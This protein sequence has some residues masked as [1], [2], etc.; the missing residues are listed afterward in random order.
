M[1][2]KNPQLPIRGDARIA[3]KRSSSEW[4]RV[5]S[6]LSLGDLFLE[7]RICSVD[8]L[9]YV[10]LCSSMFEKSMTPAE[11]CW[12]LKWKK[13]LYP[14]IF[15]DVMSHKPQLFVSCHRWAMSDERWG[16][17]TLL[18]P[19]QITITAKRARERVD[20]GLCK[21]LG[22]TVTRLLPWLLGHKGD[23]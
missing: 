10:L 15:N 20:F 23:S 12:D 3:I 21:Q 8:R 4:R 1:M 9:I 17:A 5:S 14:G 16:I 2:A 11:N 18:I 13:I 19:S 7:F 6:W 22:L